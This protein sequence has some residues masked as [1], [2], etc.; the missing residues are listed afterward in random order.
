[1]KIEISTNDIKYAEKILLPE[2][3]SFDTER[4]DFIKKLDTIDLQAV[5]GSGKTTAL[6][7]KLLI[8]ERYIPFSNG[9][10]I[11]V[12]SHTN[13]AIDEIKNKIGKYCPRLFS[14]PNFIGTIQSFVD[15]FLAIPF[16]T[17]EFKKK[18]YRIDNEIYNE[19]SLFLYNSLSWS[20]KN[21]L[22][23]KKG[24]HLDA[25]EFFST[26]RINNNKDLLREGINGKVFLKNKKD[27]SESYIDIK[28]KKETLMRDWGYL[29]FDDAYFLADCYLQKFP[30]IKKLLQ[31]R[32][33]F[34]FVDEMQDMDKHQYDLLENVFYA[35]GNSISKYQR[36]GDLNQAIH[37]NISSDDCWTVR[38]NSLTLTGSHRLTPEIAKVVKCFGLNYQE[39]DG[40]RKSCAI[41]PHIIVF[42]DPKEV[43]PKFTKLIKENNLT[44]KKHPFCAIGWIG[45]EKTDSLT[46]KCYHSDFEKN[47][48]KPKIDY[49]C[50]KDYLKYFEKREDSLAPS[51]KNILNAILM[52]L[53]KENEKD[54]TGRN[55][56]ITKFLNCVKENDL[57]K[58]NELKFKLFEW[59]FAIKKGE[60][61][62][63]DLKSYIKPFLKD[64]F[65]DINF[66]QQ[67]DDFINLS[68]SSNI[69]SIEAEAR[70][71][72]NNF[73][74]SDGIKIK[75][76]TVHS[77]KGETHTATL[78]M[79][80]YYH[81]RNGKN[82]YESERLSQQI[83]GNKFSETKV[84]HKQSLKMA[85]V[86]FSR[87]T[88]LL[89]FAVHKDRIDDNFNNK[90]WE[91]IEI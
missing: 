42:E 39:I 71:K 75:I 51:R 43:L 23:N 81:G 29:C 70:Y 47:H 10:G 11:L 73:F 14:Y 74:E 69:E 62:Y 44:D 16:Y 50:L 56:T 52:I 80:T 58:Y 84:Y 22:D 35:D 46:I 45:K 34:V 1:M 26:I 38:Q 32:F 17:N 60:D 64:L 28:S 12:I 54:E 27:S 61:V 87:P 5:P 82:G 3:E 15:Q 20:T 21:Y 13:I 83:N 53:R 4:R 76:G 63:E 68:E 79:E 30:H 33:R 31:K 57:E 25:Y 59:S 48:H 37:N 8:L 36:I 78:Y 90:N 86:G 49:K 24:Q 6:L 85:Y 89:C 19:K 18:P 2:G 67:T 91:I 55:Y 9:S 77:V 7:A 41:K 40:L 72:K 88:H 66:S 65:P